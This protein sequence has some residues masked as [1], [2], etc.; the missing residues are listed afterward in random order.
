MGSKTFGSKKS[1]V[2]KYCDPKIFEGPKIV[3]KKIVVEFRQGSI[4][5]I[6]SGLA[7]SYNVWR[8]RAMLG[9]GSYCCSSCSCYRGKT[10]STST[11]TNKVGSGLQVRSGV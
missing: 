8:R 7:T 9:E 4:G 10:K 3:T 11:P 2:E 5:T 1:A 6:R